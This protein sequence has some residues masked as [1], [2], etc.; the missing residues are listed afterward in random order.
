MVLEYLMHT[1]C[2]NLPFELFHCKVLTRKK[3][4]T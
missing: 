2:I 1:R 4:F 3:G